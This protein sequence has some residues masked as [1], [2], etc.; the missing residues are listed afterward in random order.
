MRLRCF[1]ILWGP[2]T[3]S[4]G[5]NFSAELY[6][7]S[8]PCVVVA[9]CSRYQPNILE[10]FRAPWTF[11]FSQHEIYFLKCVP[12]TFI[13]NSLTLNN[14]FTQMMGHLMKTT[15]FLGIVRAF[16]KLL[17]PRPRKGLTSR[18]PRS[19]KVVLMFMCKHRRSDEEM[20]LK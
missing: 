4:S 1:L 16:N 20:Y 9:S 10:V 8:Y 19:I 6:Y 17:N 11:G 3:Y 5:M 2:M 13:S 18:K 7:T 15:K 14:Q 12:H